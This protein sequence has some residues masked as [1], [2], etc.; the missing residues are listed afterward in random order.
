MLNCLEVSV[1]KRC[2]KNKR[3]LVWGHINKFRSAVLPKCTLKVIIL[4][5]FRESKCNPFLWFFL[6]FH[7][8][9][10]Q[11]VWWVFVFNC[12]A[13]PRK[14]Q[15][16]GFGSWRW[17]TRLC[18][19][20]TPYCK[21]R[22]E[23]RWMQSEKLRSKWLIF[24]GNKGAWL[25]GV[26][27]CTCPGGVRG[28]GSRVSPSPGRAAGLGTAVLPFSLCAWDRPNADSRGNLYGKSLQLIIFLQKSR[29][30]S[31]KHLMLGI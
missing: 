17:S 23:E 18:N 26:S 4:A 1:W 27:D 24:R 21:N 30:D 28:W 29:T 25:C 31:L 10:K 13:W 16:C 14:R 7:C 12:R 20:L 6:Y 11:L 22:S 19:E 2:L 5:R 9:R 3:Q 15:N 8:R